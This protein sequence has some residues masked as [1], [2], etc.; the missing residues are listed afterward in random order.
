MGARGAGDYAPN[1]APNY[2]V[3]RLS[4][5]GTQDSTY[6]S[7]I[8]GSAPRF[9]ALQPDGKLLAGCIDPPDKPQPNGVLTNLMRLTTNGSPDPAFHS[10]VFS[11][12]FDEIEQIDS[13]I[14]LD[15][16]GS[17]YIAGGFMQVDGQSRQQIA[18]LHADGTL[19]TAFVPGG[20]ISALYIR[21]ILLQ[22]GGKVV[23]AG[24]FRFNGSSTFYPLLRLNSDGSLDQSFTLVP[25][26]DIDFVRARV[27][28]STSD[29]K[30]LTVGTSMARFNSD[31]SLDDTFTRVGFLDDTGVVGLSK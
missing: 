7:P 20:F 27:L 9:L 5:N 19:D 15:T 31:G 6:Q 17:I 25:S 21:G 30:I 2:R 10:P 8:F 22:A 23:I 12:G 29:G 18:R 14:A 26:S 13:P 4:T 28:R 3:F 11:G 16:D 1:G 24:R